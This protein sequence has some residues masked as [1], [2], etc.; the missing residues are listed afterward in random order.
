V[1]ASGYISQSDR[2]RHGHHVAGHLEKPFSPD[3]MLRVVRQ[4]LDQD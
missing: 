3:R 4:V 1:I 2:E